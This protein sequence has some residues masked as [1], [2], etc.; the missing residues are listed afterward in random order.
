MNI[1]C[2]YCNATLTPKSLKPGR[3]APKCPKC[4]RPFVLDVPEDD[5]ADVTVEEIDPKPLPK[6]KPVPMLHRTKPPAD[7]SD[8]EDPPVGGDE[9]EDTSDD[10]DDVGDFDREAVHKPPEKPLPKTQPFPLVR[11]PK[12]PEPEEEDE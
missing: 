10:S 1:A 7:P 8:D 12:K 9:N 5:E 11:K 2:P 6:T 3:Y 4:G